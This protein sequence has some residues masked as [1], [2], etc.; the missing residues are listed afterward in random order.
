MVAWTGVEAMWWK[1]MDK[2]AIVGRHIDKTKQ[3]IKFGAG[4]R[5]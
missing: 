2:F 3:W 1:E 4:E 5:I